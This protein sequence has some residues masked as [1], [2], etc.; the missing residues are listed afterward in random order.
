MFPG[1]VHSLAARYDLR[2]RI[3]GLL[4][5]E[6]ERGPA[7]CACGTVAKDSVGIERASVNV[8]RRVEGEGVS[9]EGVFRCDSG[10]LCPV[11]APRRAREVQDRVERVAAAAVAKGVWVV[12]ITLTLRHDRT[13][14]LAPLKEALGAAY[15]KAQQGNGFKVYR[16]RSG[17]LGAV[18]SME[19]R[20]SLATGWH[21][22]IHALAFFQTA[23]SEDALFYG[24][25]LAQRYLAK[26]T[27][28]GFSATRSGQDVQLCTDP[29]G[30]GRYAAKGALELANGWAKTY[31]GKRNRSFHPFE[32]VQFGT[33][34]GALGLPRGELLE[35]FRE[36]AAVFPGTGQCRVSRQ[37]AQA[38]DVPPADDQDE[39]GATEHGEGLEPVGLSVAAHVWR[40][41]A[42][43]GLTGRFLEEYA[44]RT[45][46]PD[47][48]GLFE[49]WAERLHLVDDP[50][51]CF[52]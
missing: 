26:L 7:V 35:R 52:W 23:R 34:P 12:F 30:A 20:Y 18:R 47:P 43:A 48:G 4:R 31:D 33:D 14:A 13:Q 28:A 29:E 41:M 50:E 11:C 38:L 9:V 44:T 16:A 10:W 45:A 37:L 51:L 5:P 8:K 24:E 36:Y 27:A 17:F 42:A 21:P 6:E 49:R 40:R 25:E 46:P 3:A 32:L 2:N 39:P 22:H 19:V 1:G 15:R